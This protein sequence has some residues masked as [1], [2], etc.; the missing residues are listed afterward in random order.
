MKDR[1]GG[2]TT[3]GLVEVVGAMAL[4]GSSVVV[5]KILATRVPVFLSAELSLLAALAAIL[6]AQAVKWRELRLV[7][8][9]DLGA[10]FLQALFGIVLFRALTLYGLHFT[11]AAQAGL[12]T[13]AAPAVMA[14]LASLLL[15]ERA[16]GRVWLGVALAV[17]GL[18]AVNLQG[19]F[20]TPTPGFLLGNLLVLGA[21]VCEALLTIF[22]KASG[23]RIGS[24]TN[25]TILVAMS[26]VLLLPF[27]LA[28]MRSFPLSRIETVGWIVIVYYGSVAT[29]IAY[30]LWGDGALR[31]PASL[32]G[33]ATSALPVTALALSAFVLGEKLTIAH[34]LGCAAIVAGMI[35]GRPRGQPRSYS[36]SQTDSCGPRPSPRAAAG[37]AER[38]HSDLSRRPPDRRS[39]TRTGPSTERVG[40]AAARPGTTARAASIPRRPA[41]TRP[42]G[43]SG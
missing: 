36:S 8:L 24:V 15:G 6:P 31:I 4:A 39:E 25:T 33:I 34:G 27:A 18:A 11:T 1:T 42:S 43:L 30:I 7:R 14:V 29:V 2:A 12:V 20:S 13:S 22:R 21:T 9:K 28:D 10:M 41:R 35:V 5:G 19:A 38:L 26:A 3:R 40:A 37:R 23:G 16:A 17:A 32:T